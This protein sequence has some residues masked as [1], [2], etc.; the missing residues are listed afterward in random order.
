MHAAI[1]PTAAYAPATPKFLA[2]AGPAELTAEAEQYSHDILAHY[3]GNIKLYNAF[4]EPDLSQAYSFTI[5][6]LENLVS[7]AIRGARQG[8]P[9]VMDFVNVS[10]PVFASLRYEWAAAARRLQ[11]SIP[12]CKWL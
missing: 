10:I 1:W 4:N 2:T 11:L 8:D 7:A 12:G 9:K 3:G 6:E 5:D